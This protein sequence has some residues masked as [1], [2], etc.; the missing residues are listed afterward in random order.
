MGQYEISVIIP[1]KDSLATLCRLLKS[2][3]FS[4]KLEV[5]VID[6]SLNRIT[7]DEIG[8]GAKFRLLYSDT[9]KYAGGARNVGINAAN[10]KWLLFADAD[11]FFTDDAFDVFFSY[12]KE[13]GND[14]VYF[15]SDSV[16]DDTLLPS[17]RNVLFN[18][19]VENYLLGKISKLDLCLS[20]VVPWCK[21]IKR[22]FVKK[23]A[24]K[25]DEVIAANDVMF[26]TLVG[27]YARN[28]AV[29]SRKVYVVTTKKGSLSN[30]LDLSVVKARY[31]VALN[32]NKFLRE[33]GLGNKQGSVMI[34]FYRS[35]FFGIKVMARFVLDAVEYRQNPFIGCR[36]WV[37]TYLNL[38]KK[39]NLNR[40]YIIR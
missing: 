35:L 37:S 29:D 18:S 26:S 20:Y 14:V 31:H 30:R 5:I 25:F 24:I 28:I 13:G 11:D 22:D 2:I 27:Y 3:P 16:F 15:R 1:H 40:K 38:R 19:Y 32:R 21:L 7:Y 33:H 34:Y 39:E 36:N 4:D 17:D 10:G 12:V 9:S 8:F 6:N 23:Y